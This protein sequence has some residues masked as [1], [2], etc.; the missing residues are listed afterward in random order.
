M[1]DAKR[2]AD[3]LVAEGKRL[4]ESASDVAEATPTPFVDRSQTE[5][6]CSFVK[7]AAEATPTP[8]VD[9]SQAEAGGSFVEDPAEATPAADTER[10][11]AEASGAGVSDPA[12]ANAEATLER[13]AEGGEDVPKQVPSLTVPLDPNQASKTQLYAA[14]S[15]DKGAR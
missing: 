15:N 1:S 6:S 7:D 8:D 4:K 9:R 12:T 11:Q 5:A 2:P 10:S 3:D 13:S 14:V